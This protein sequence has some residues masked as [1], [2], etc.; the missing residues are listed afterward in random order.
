MQAKEGDEKTVTGSTTKRGYQK[1]I[2]RL[3]TKKARIDRPKTKA[4]NS[5]V[6]GCKKENKPDQKRRATDYTKNQTKKARIDRPKTKAGNS[7][8]VG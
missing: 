4:G 5:S 1:G 7:S 8:V 6:V 2:D 3:Q